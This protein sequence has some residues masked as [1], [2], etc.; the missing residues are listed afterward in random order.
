MIRE[1][2]EFDIKIIEPQKRGLLNQLFIMVNGKTTG[3]YPVVLKNDNKPS[4]IFILTE[5]PM[6]D[7]CISIYKLENDSCYLIYKIYT[8]MSDII[9]RKAN[10]ISAIKEML[11]DD[12]KE[13]YLLFMSIMN[14]WEDIIVNKRI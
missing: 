11:A 14:M 1:K 7:G 2:V 13:L 12:Q 5:K 4:D 3:L 10:K 9:Q 8:S 6:F